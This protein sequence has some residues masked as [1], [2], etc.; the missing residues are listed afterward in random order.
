MPLKESFSSLGHGVKKLAVEAGVA[1]IGSAVPQLPDVIA[2]APVQ[3]RLELFKQ[4]YNH[5]NGVYPLQEAY[6]DLLPHIQDDIQATQ[7]QIKGLG[8]NNK[9]ALISAGAMVLLRMMSKPGLVKLAEKAMAGD[10]KKA[11]SAL[12]TADK[13][14]LGLQAFCLAGTYDILVKGGLQTEAEKI[15]AISGGVVFVGSVLHAIVEKKVKAKK[16]PEAAQ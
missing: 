10:N 4:I 5:L 15:M 11:V 7:E 8:F 13:L 16:Q 3:Q 9:E 1:F 14:W 6:T 2:I 12:L